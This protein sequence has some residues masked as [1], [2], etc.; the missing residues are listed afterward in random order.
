ME[1]SDKRDSSSSA[2][3]LILIRFLFL[4]LAPNDLLLLA[5]LFVPLQCYLD[6]YLICK[7]ARKL[8]PRPS[9]RPSVCWS[10]RLDSCAGTEMT[11]A[12]SQPL[13]PLLLL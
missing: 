7:A 10:G 9:V 3:I 13:P 6:R 1:Y 4:F 2:L 5:G 8:A 11:A 12:R